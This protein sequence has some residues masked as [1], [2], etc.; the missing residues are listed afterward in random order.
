MARQQAWEHNARN[1]PN[2]KGVEKGVDEDT[3][4]ALYK[5]MVQK[6]HMKAGALHTIIADGVWTPRR[7]HKREKN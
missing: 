2:Y 1:R 3:T 7:A 4:R 5:H 6:D